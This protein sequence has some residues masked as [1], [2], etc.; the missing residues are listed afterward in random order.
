MTDTL[1]VAGAEL[2]GTK[3]IAVLAREREIIERITVP[4]TRPDE[5]LAAL[6]AILRRW[7]D[8][9]GIAA[10]GIASFGPIRLDPA[11]ADHGCMLATP[12]PGW[13]GAPVA[14][15]LTAG[16]DI[17]WRIDTD[18]NGAALAEWQ[19]GAGQG[20]D[21]IC[22]VTVGTGVGGG[23]VINGAP[24]HGAMHPELG[25]LRLRRADGDSFP[26]TCAF[27]RD[28]IEGLVAGPALARRLGGDPAQIVDGDPRWSA[29]ASDLAEL[30]GAV[31]LVTSAQR[32]LFGGGVMTARPLLLAKVRELVVQRLESYLPFLSAQNAV[33]MI[34]VPALGADAGPL[35]AVVLAL[36]AYRAPPA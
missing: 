18:V 3:S 32:I 8:E 10:L 14:A 9:G 31:L 33:T 36:A 20:C 25:H 27:H 19:W 16:L 35:G 12:K 13:R 11:A 26:G 1:L 34:D 7:R 24:V 21:S 15:T 2:G 30:A 22:Y 29:V 5:T 17:P 4:T 6:H 23:L 28:C